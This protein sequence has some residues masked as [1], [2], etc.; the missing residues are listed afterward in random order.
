MFI[1]Y[2]KINGI[3]DNDVWKKYWSDYKKH[4]RVVK[5]GWKERLIGVFGKKN[6]IC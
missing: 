4:N 3:K 2:L 5:K 6:Q 1:D